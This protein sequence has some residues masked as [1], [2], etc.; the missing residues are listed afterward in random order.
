MAVEFYSGRQTLIDLV[1]DLIEVN[2]DA[3][4]GYMRAAEAIES[5]ALT[6]QLKQFARQ[7][8][9]CITDLSTL[10]I[11]LSGEPASERTA[12]GQPNRAWITI[13]TLADEG[14]R[15]AILKE[16]E[17]GE[18]VVLQV[19]ESALQTP[20]P[21]NISK[22]LREQFETLQKAH[23]YVKAMRIVEQQ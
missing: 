13:G 12:T 7:H 23:D 19:Y 1:N 22:V 6:S 11:S 17:V 4:T 20:L 14:D 8:D 18:S 10:V 15:E 21:E 2:R 5:A 9:T 3:V 16:C